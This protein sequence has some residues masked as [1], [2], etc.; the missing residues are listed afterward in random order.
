MEFASTFTFIITRLNEAL[1][2]AIVIIAFS[3]FVYM[4]TYNLRSSIGRA[5]A[6][7]LACMCFAYAGDV[8]IYKVTNIEDALPWLKF[9]WIGIAFIPAA[10]L[11]FADVLLRATNAISPRR[12]FTVFLAYF[13][14]FLILLLAIQTD[15]LVRD[16]F[17]SPGVTQFRSG[18]FFWIFT[19]YFYTTL[20]WGAY[21]VYRARARCLTSGARKRMTY[22]AVSF[23]APALGV[24]P[25]MLIANAPKLMPPAILFITL[26]LVN[27]G[28]AIMIIV[29]AYSVVFFG[30]MS[31]DRVI[32]HNL[33]HLLLRGSFVAAM[34][35][36]IMQAL[37]EH[38]Q[39]LGLPRELILATSIVT[40]IV[41]SQLF[42]NTLKPAIDSIIFYQDRNE[43]RWISEL[44]RRLLTTS[45]L[46]Q[47]LENI[48]IILCENLRVRTGFIYNLAAN[49]GPRLEAYTG[50][51]EDVEEAIANIDVN[52][53][54]AQKNGS[55]GFHFITQ[56]NFWFVILKTQS[57]D[58]SLGLL[59]IEA[60][61]AEYD[62]TPDEEEITALLLDHAE[63]ALEDR[64]LQQQIF[65]ALRSIIPDIKRVQRLSSAVSYAG[66]SNLNLLTEENPIHTPD[67]SKMVKD[68]LSHYWGGPKLT[69]S[70][71]LNLR[72]VQEA[73]SEND[74]NQ[75][76]ALRSV[77]EQAIEKQRPEGERQLTA[78]EWLI[79]N[80]LELKFIQGMRVRDIANRL[81]MS[82]ADLYRKQRLAIEEVARTLSEMETQNGVTDMVQLQASE[83]ENRNVS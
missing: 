61:D 51:I 8:A 64:R 52:A 43:I 26:F 12:R 65:A 38:Q 33:I 14:G 11:H 4:F 75:S 42:I 54:I 37:P 74:G 29:M 59:G 57:R 83:R 34:V 30:A 32:K 27:L 60:R 9:Q 63:Q 16:P 31:P 62:L 48:L 13:F 1:S 68:A 49:Q 20:L 79:Y 41:L 50:P 56:N 35:I 39:I 72:V 15:Y 18:P 55:D 2:S 28:I 19:C 67:F 25:Y 82:E 77:L 47:A 36:A 7:L 44:D 58:R 53:L 69:K 6:V 80:I 3:L 40:V 10:Y 23:V 45:D 70:P 46:Q 66:A 24:Y 22:L 76:K 81:A 73:I 71:L 21:K 17:Y 78:A 5:F